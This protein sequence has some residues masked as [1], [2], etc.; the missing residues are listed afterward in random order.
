[1]I[2][3]VSPKRRYSPTRRH[4][5]GNLNF[6]ISRKRQ[7]L[8]I[9]FAT[10]RPLWRRGEILVK[11]LPMKNRQHK[12]PLKKLSQQQRVLASFRLRLVITCIKTYIYIYIWLHALRDYY[13][14]G[15][16]YGLQM[17]WRLKPKH[18]TVVVIFN[19]DKHLFWRFFTSNI[20]YVQHKG[21]S[22]IKINSF[23][24]HRDV[25]FCQLVRNRSAANFA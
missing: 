18:D 13:Y 20:L 14:Q 1:M 15:C 6:D 22:H 4:N 19:F 17:G 21:I 25:N 11:I 2:Q 8:Q 9:C 24:L 10:G 7:I 16:R 5:P 23:L 3:H 12:Y